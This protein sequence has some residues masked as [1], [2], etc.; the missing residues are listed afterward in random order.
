M[1]E[2]STICVIIPA[3]GGSKRL[4]NKNIYPV[5]GKPM[6]A[7]SVKAAHNSKYIDKIFISTE[8]D[9]IKDVAR[10]LNVSIHNRDSQLSKDHIFKME[11]VR[12]AISFIEKNDKKYD[13]YIS[14]QANS[15]QINKEIIDSAIE[16]FFYYDRNEL[17]SV[18]NNLMQN[19]A[20]RI[21]KA[22]YA[23]YKDLSTKCGVYV[24]DLIDVHTIEDVNNLEAMM[25]YE[26]I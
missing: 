5:L 19:A 2:N 6:I 8:S 15:P 23:M 7:W 25:T 14:L 12:S 18:D 9:K 1:F 21:M 4:K 11:A 17:L 26:K 16:K 22:D 10:S 20:F 13:V 24:C 3:R